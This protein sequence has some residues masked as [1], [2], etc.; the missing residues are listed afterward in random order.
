LEFLKNFTKKH[1]MEWTFTSLNTKIE[2][3]YKGKDHDTELRKII[4]KT[5]H[6]T[7]G[8]RKI[9]YY[10]LNLLIDKILLDRKNENNLINWH[11]F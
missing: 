3:M 7:S 8:K 2:K 4:E 5:V 11:T 1:D 10:S 9:K 6:R